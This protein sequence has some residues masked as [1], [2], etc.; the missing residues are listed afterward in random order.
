MNNINIQ[1]LVEYNTI[2]NE[3]NTRCNKLHV[4]HQQ[5]T[6]CKKGCS[7]C[8]MD[9]SVLPIEFYAIL[10]AIKDNP[11]LRYNK[12]EGCA[13]LVDNTCSIYEHRPS[14]CRSHGL[15]ILNMDETGEQMEL[16]FCPLNF[17][18]VDDNYFTLDNG[19]QQDVF[20][21]KLYIANRKF[22]KEF[23]QGDFSENELIELQKLKNY[24]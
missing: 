5:H 6:M 15:P 13:F 4:I 14:I 12:K 24:L 23:K 9:F 16:S 22:I 18:K 21:S 20:N 17:T 1:Y 8:C 2:I 7:Q 3:L 11:P 19:F 10:E